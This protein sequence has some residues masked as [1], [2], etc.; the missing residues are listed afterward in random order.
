[1]YLCFK[2]ARER[3]EWY[4]VFRSLAKLSS[5]EKTRLARPHRRLKVGIY[6][7]TEIQSLQ[8]WSRRYG[9]D[10][11]QTDDVT[12]AESISSSTRR[13]VSQTLSTGGKS[14]QSSDR[15]RSRSHAI[16]PGWSWREKIRLEL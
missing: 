16:H 12:S 13:Q 5:E 2:T 10:S 8:P 14:T 11:S 4:T 1:M 15:G 7:L 6:D 3:D 9:D